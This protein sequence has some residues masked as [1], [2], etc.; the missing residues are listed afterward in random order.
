MT[1]GATAGTGDEDGREKEI[2]GCGVGVGR[3][4]ERGMRAAESKRFT[5]SRFTYILLASQRRMTARHLPEKIRMIHRLVCLV[6]FFAV[7]ALGAEDR[8]RSTQEELRRRNVYFGD[9]DGKQSA[10]YSE[11]LRRYQKRKGLPA[12]GQE[13]HDTLRSL[14]L[15]PRSPNEPPPKELDWPAEPVLKSDTHLDV[16]AAG[17][18]LADETGVAPTE[19]EGVEPDGA[20]QKEPIRGHAAVPVRLRGRTGV[21]DE[22]PSPT[23]PARLSFRNSAEIPAELNDFVAQYLRAVS[24]DRLK[25]ELH[26][27]A[28]RVDY[29][30]S[31]QV[32]RRI[33]EQTLRKYY[34]RWPKRSYSLASPVNYQ[35]APN[36]GEIVLTYRLNFSLANGNKH[37]KGQTDN[38]LT[39]NA[40]TADPRIIAISEQRIRR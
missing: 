10:E 38:R 39:I 31:R 7:A 19:V 34:Q 13:D 14:G 18:E 9:I 8:V 6:L 24:R 4:D 33:I 23:H 26:F 32:D 35:L 25:D 27:Y 17:R 37:V 28:D 29:F 5:D 21:P 15:A 20:P 16:V 12:T 2:G 36:R 11:A 22:K 3:A 30:G 40:A 1:K